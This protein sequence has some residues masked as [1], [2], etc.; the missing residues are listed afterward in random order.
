VTA[1]WSIE[2]RLA[3]LRG[4]NGK[5]SLLAADHGLT[6]GEVPGLESINDI[7]TTAR[8]AAVSGVVTNY[9]TLQAMPA[10]IPAGLIMQ[11]YGGLRD[12][13]GTG[14]KHRLYA[15]SQLG[16]LAIDGIAIEL[17]LATSAESV[18]SRLELIASST[19]EAH[20]I[21]LPVL[22]MLNQLGD[23]EPAAALLASARI[24]QELGAD[25]I[26]VGIDQRLGTISMNERRELRN[27]IR[28]LPPLV[29]AGGPTTE[30]L[31]F[32]LELA[33]DLGFSGA[34]V[35]RH[36]FSSHDV[37]QSAVRIFGTEALTDGRPSN[38]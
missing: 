13:T 28:H 38:P 11:T 27:H 12:A 36:L 23:R 37:A 5:F 6:F 29:L 25:I 21:G 31:Y 30:D 35:G 10:D 4:S 2:R 3:R 26:K 1:N 18:N 34:C 32:K 19:L 17:N 33:A 7:V 24:A 14:I 8:I 9:G 20:R 22:A 16:H 15:P